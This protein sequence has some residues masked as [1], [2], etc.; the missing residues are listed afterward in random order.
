M[1]RDKFSYITMTVI[2]CITAVFLGLALWICPIAMAASFDCNKATTR[3]EKMICSDDTLSKLDKDL[4]TEYYWLNKSLVYSS[5]TTDKDRILAE[6][7]KWL[8]EER[9]ICKDTE[10]IR[11]AYGRRIKQIGWERGFSHIASNLTYRYMLALSV[12]S[13]VDAKRI[14]AEHNK[15]LTSVRESCQDTA[16]L[17]SAYK[18]RFAQLKKEAEQDVRQFWDTDGYWY[19]FA[20]KLKANDSSLDPIIHYSLDASDALLEF[21]VG[22]VGSIWLNDQRFATQEELD[23]LTDM[24]NGGSREWQ[25]LCNGNMI[26]IEDDGIPKF[27][28]PMSRVIIRTPQQPDE[29]WSREYKSFAII[30]EL[31]PPKIIEEIRLEIHEDPSVPLLIPLWSEVFRIK[32]LKDCTSL[33]EIGGGAGGQRGV[34]R[35]RED[36]TTEAV[37]PPGLRLIDGQEI[38]RWVDEFDQSF[39]GGIGMSLQP[40]L[41][42]FYHKIFEG[43]NQ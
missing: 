31:D 28:D 25:P 29:I 5:E 10:C 39:E 22:S 23:H 3:V 26:R 27:G 13:E 11:L 12:L 20:K 2:N 6:Q 36:G 40:K 7:R 42:F 1:G 17:R 14:Q 35:F 18:K 16:C 9:N 4:A 30:R 8:K 15:W 24:P 43:E 37:L 32:V 41:W 21:G 19:F 34:V 38:W 33:A